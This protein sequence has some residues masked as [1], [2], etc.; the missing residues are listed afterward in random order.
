MSTP[1]GFAGKTIFEPGAYGQIKSGLPTPLIST[2]TGNVLIIDT[3]SASGFGAAGINGELRSGKDSVYRFSSP[4]DFK[5]FMGGGEWTK[6]ID[7][8]AKPKRGSNGASNIFF[9]HARSTTAAVVNIPLTNGIDGGTLNFKVKQEGVWGNGVET[10][11]VLSQGYAWTVEAGVVDT[12]AFVFKFWRGTFRGIDA[13]GDPYKVEASKTKP[14]LLAES[15]EVTTVQE[16]ES[17]MNSSGSFQTY[18]TKPTTTVTTN[19]AID[20]ADITA[21]AGNN[22]AT[23]GTEAYSPSD[24]EDV[25]DVLNGIDFTFLLLDKHGANA[26]GTENIQILNHLK[27]DSNFSKYAF[28]GGGDTS[29]KFSGSADSSVDIAV[30]LDTEKAVV[31][32]SGIDNIDY[33]TGE[34]KEGLSAL[35]SAAG[36]L[37]RIAGLEPQESITFKDFDFTKVTHLPSEKQRKLAI[38]KGV[39]HFRDVD[40][41]VVINEGVN[42]L[43]DNTK[44]FNP[45][46]TSRDIAVERIKAQVNKTL[47][48]N[49]RNPRTGLVGKNRNTASAEDVKLFTEGILDSLTATD[50]DDNLIVSYRNVTVNLVD[51][52]Y[53]DVKY[54]F[55]P[56]SPIN[57]LLFT[58]FI[59]DPTL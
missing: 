27:N 31:V 47:V 58:G 37:G 53:W 12:S 28:I 42:T 10:G 30:A 1:R 50:Q 18:F 48:L 46:G 3:D 5:F 22:L 34:L 55:E 19:G 4:E 40:G 23:G 13:N 20:P 54:S 35:Y 2:T 16:L 11:S 25:L 59:F 43:Q 9:I 26:T 44:L 51:S 21:N 41:F 8:L 33:E 38:R 39:L 14:N 6:L 36:V 52:Q 49:A 56:N 57:G 29:D 45:D 32:H 7:Y 15:P 17:W 24:I